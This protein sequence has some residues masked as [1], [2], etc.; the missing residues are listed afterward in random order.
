MVGLIWVAGTNH[1][2]QKKS[3][4]GLASPESCDLYLQPGMESSPLKHLG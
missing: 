1:S 4:L 3:V 2:G